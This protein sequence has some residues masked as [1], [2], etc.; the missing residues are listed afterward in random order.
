MKRK[1]KI[2]AFVCL[3]TILYQTFS[4]LTAWALTSGPISPDA[5]S[6]EPV[7]TST[8][9]NPLTGDFVYN[10]P[11]MEVPGPEGSYPLSL[12][13]HAG[14]NPEQES[15][16]VGLGWTLNP[17]SITRSVSGFPD[18]WA[19]TLSSRRDY[20][21][22]GVTNVTSVGVNIPVINVSADV[23]VVKDTYK[24]LGVGWNVAY[25][26]G[27]SDV[28]QAKIGI[29]S[30]P[31]S[32]GF[33]VTGGLSAGALSLMGSVGENSNVGISISTPFNLLGASLSTQG[34]GF[35]F[36]PAV[37]TDLSNSKEGIVQT[38]TKRTELNLIF[39]N[40][41]KTR[42]R[43]WSDETEN[44][45]IYGAL[46]SQSF[47]GLLTDNSLVND[48]YQL[49]TGHIG[50]NEESNPEKLQNGAFPAFD[51]YSVTGQGLGGYMRPFLFQGSVSK[52]NVIERESSS[53]TKMTVQYGNNTKVSSN[54]GFRFVGDFSNTLQQ[55]YTPF[56]TD[57]NT[58]LNS[59]LPFASPTGNGANW[60]SGYNATN[61]VLT[62]SKAIQYFKTD[63]NGDIILPN[64]SVKFIQPVAQGLDRKKHVGQIAVGA[65]NASIKSITGFSITNESG[66]TYHYN[67]PAYNYDEE[68]YQENTVRA[69]SSD[70][71]F[72]RQTK[73][74]GY[75]YTWHLT[76]VTGPDYV[77]RGSIGVLDEAD[78]GYWVSFEYGKWSDEFVWR[79]PTE[80]FTRNVDQHFFTVSMGKKEVYYLNAIKTRTHTALFEK[81]VRSDG[82]SASKE[83]F[84][85]NWSSQNNVSTDYSNQGL[86]N[87]NSNQSLRLSHIYILK[88]DI[89]AGIN[90]AK[91]GSGGLIPVGRSVVCSE[92]ELPNNIL[93][94]NDV[95]S[96]GR[97]LLEANSL[98]VID[99]NFDYSLAKGSTTSF[100]FSNPSSKLGKLT[101]KSFKVRGKGGLSVLPQT[102]FG[103]NL[104]TIDQKKGQGTIATGSITG[105]NSLYEV[106]DLIETDETNPIY[107]GYVDQVTQ[108]GSTYN[109]V[110]KGNE[111]LGN[112]G[113]KSIR[114][115]KN[116]PYQNDKYDYWGMYKSDYVYYY[117][118]NI[119]RNPTKIS[120][121]S[122]D[123]WS[124][125]TIKTTGGPLVEV[126]F[127]GHDFGESEYSQ[128]MSVRFMSMTKLSAQ[129]YRL[130]MAP[131]G[132]QCKDMYQ[133]G[134]NMLGVF[135][136]EFYQ[137]NP[138]NNNN[139]SMST[140]SID[141]IDPNSTKIYD[142]YQGAVVLVKAVN[143]NTIDVE[144]SASF[145]QSLFNVGYLD[146]SQTK[147]IDANFCPTPYGKKYLGGNGV[148]VKSITLKGLDGVKFTTQY[149]YTNEDQLNSSGVAN[150]E[151][152]NYDSYE[153]AAPVTGY[154]EIRFND[155]LNTGFSVVI[156][157][158]PELSGPNMMYSRVETS[159]KVE[160]PD[161]S[162]DTSPEK[163]VSEFFTF[164]DIKIEKNYASN[165]NSSSTYSIVNLVLRKF[166]SL[167]G[168]PKSMSYYDGNG[169]LTK[170][171]IKQYLH[172]G[173]TGNFF[174]DYKVRLE[175]FGYQ[176]L[177]AER[178]SEVK[179]VLKASN[180]TFVTMGTMIARED[181][182]LVNTG[183]VEYDY[184][185]NTKTSTR[186]NAFDFYSGAVTESIS[187]D[188]YGNSFLTKTQ[189]AYNNYPAMG[190]SQLIGSN[191]NMLAQV[192]SQN[193]YKLNASGVPEYLVSASYNEWSNKGQV[194]NETGA[195][196]I[197]DG[198]VSANGNVWRQISDYIWMP[199]TAAANGMT[200]AA[201]FVAFPFA[202]PST[203]NISWKNNVTTT[204]MD[205]YSHTL[206]TRDFKGNSAS[207]R[208][209]YNNAKTVLSGSFAKY[210]EIV[211][212]GA[213]DDNL[214]NTKL[215][216]VK[217]GT[218]TLSTTVMHTGQQSIQVGAGQTAFEYTAP[219]SE[220]TVGRTY[221]ASIWVNKG[222]VNNIK[223]YYQL[224]NV[225]KAVSL[226]SNVST[227]TSGDWTL[228]HFD[229]PV[230]TGT[231][232]K[233]FA[234]ND[235]STTTYVD[236]FR[237]QPKNG[238]A[239]AYVYDGK[240][241]ELTHTLD[242]YNLFTRYEYN[243]M[244]Q[245]VTTYREQFGRVPYKSAENQ[246]NY[247]TKSFIGLGN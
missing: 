77:D 97:T 110:L 157:Y 24:G 188:A 118:Q 56:S 243:A 34:S 45:N 226:A 92:C 135:F 55:D 146:I 8:M 74:A 142:A 189:A 12:S 119:S 223:L 16:W 212:S 99:L 147:I 149:S 236:D 137:K 46:N 194:L 109:Y 26:Y 103:Y 131:N 205:P 173:I 61:Q 42:T 240:T 211:F 159:S 104:S 69:N 170:R 126:N 193:V 238:S 184:I 62:G 107:C 222:A 27:I 187:T 207:A 233:I 64:S 25:G 53:S 143:G 88:N 37:K 50:L 41:S 242:Q 30:N 98:R 18:D 152:L 185:H 201:N 100:D 133:V 155:A 114:R 160:Y 70:L 11:L 71:K 237:F 139:T 204:L 165:S 218:G 87:I 17:G 206:S 23:T 209:G 66:M 171:I 116:P 44:S 123:V 112:L 221:S 183:T 198:S 245:V 151:P 15:S 43:Y 58:I 202:N 19:N 127:E 117:N 115:T 7:D 195:K 220:L 33:S 108:N 228:I 10:V 38:E 32:S 164:K 76:A 122:T 13:Y 214:T 39:F 234:K 199:T 6:F 83:S 176:G 125:R 82:K 63:A 49:N 235:G 95:D 3:S 54:L 132:R 102:E 75:A 94:K 105:A 148:R 121:K 216:E 169:K 178:F 72:N 22:G 111:S 52:Q 134:D 89:A 136:R 144:L 153:G 150:F 106:G 229:I 51:T 60:S 78:Y 166:F 182:P 213:E 227:K 230:T 35:S 163:S 48:A 145:E 175:K 101:L 40:Y 59:T 177:V 85:K 231:N 196:I 130:T 224:D 241:G 68:T 186:V 65:S 9:V 168:S 36:S 90:P 57:A 161:G 179:K 247:S 215:L 208:Y 140:F 162:N 128:N 246:L 73:T 154:D 141:P 158:G 181:Y 197:Q 21:A 225:Q 93:D 192:A 124:L 86:F 210:G 172:D 138:E 29:G 4:P 91:G 129:N 232:V 80:G 200:L 180:N 5:S 2:F 79:S 81:D 191:K 219:V 20:W 67:L 113:L 217:K 244:G 174:D 84:N 96:Y 203:A 239:V 167:L 14:I 120:N 31:Y 47:S 28:V 190:S 156:G 1:R